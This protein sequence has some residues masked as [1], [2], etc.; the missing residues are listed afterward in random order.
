MEAAKQAGEG[1]Y[2]LGPGVVY[3]A[4]AMGRG[5]GFYGPEEAQR[6]NQELDASA[7]GLRFIAEHPELFARAAGKGMATAFEAQPMLPFRVGGRLGASALLGLAGLPWVGLAA[8]FGD[9]F[10]ALEKGHDFWDVIGRGI[11]GTPFR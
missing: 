9:A 3:L 5:Y 4:R 11:A 10:H 7:Y 2:S 6:F 8:M 1:A